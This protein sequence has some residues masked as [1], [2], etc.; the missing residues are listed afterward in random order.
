MSHPNIIIIHTTKPRGGSKG[1]TFSDTLPIGGIAGAAIREIT[2]WGLGYF[3][4][5]KV[6]SSHIASFLAL[7]DKKLCQVQYRRNEQM[8]TVE[9][10]HGN[11][12]DGCT[13]LTLDEDEFI[14]G[15]EGFSDAYCIYQ[16]TFI[17]NH[18][19]P[20]FICSFTA[21]PE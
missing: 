7:V 1:K 9:V 13:V 17:N 11:Q 4:G 2:S 21:E 14:A 5:L 10:M 16:L 12:G 15:V 6:S 19:F 18:P 3:C 8:E 20:W